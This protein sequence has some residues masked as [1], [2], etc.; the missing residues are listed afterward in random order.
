MI[1]LNRLNGTISKIGAKADKEE[2][3]KEFVQD[4]WESMYELGVN[5]IDYDQVEKYIKDNV[6]KMVEEYINYLY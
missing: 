5:I 3:I 2:I 1:N 4:V 6:T